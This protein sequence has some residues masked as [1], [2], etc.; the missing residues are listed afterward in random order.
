V[1]L[2]RQ[3]RRQR[4]LT[5]DQ[6]AALDALGFVW[7]PL[8]DDF[9]RGLAALEAYPAL[10]GQRHVP[11]GHRTA[12]GFDLGGWLNRL[13]AERRSNGLTRQQIG[14]LDALGV[15]WEPLAAQFTRGLAALRAYVEDNGHG[16]VLRTHRTPDGFRL[17]EWVNSRR[18]ERR[19]GKL[20]AE[21]IAR[22]DAAGMEW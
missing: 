16:R 6:I 14:Q 2:H 18:Y 13:R 9:A 7:D 21:S 1:H 19:K 12:D 15:I 20:T 10:A 3:N 4:K 22:L 17:G 5:G 11:T 8:A